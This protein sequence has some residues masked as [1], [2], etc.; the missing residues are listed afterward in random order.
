MRRVLLAAIFVS[1]AA[2]AAADE[3]VWRIGFLTSGGSFMGSVRSATLR[4]LAAN[5]FHEGKNIELVARWANGDPER[6]PA[7]ARELAGAKVDVIIAVSNAAIG[8][9]KAAAPETPIV[10]S[11][12]GRDPLED[13]FVR[14]YARPGGQITG[15]VMLAP[16][17]T[18]KRIQILREALPAARRVGFLA[19]ET[20]APAQIE[21]TR[22]AAAALGLSL[23]V[24]SARGPAEFSSAFAKL[25]ADGADGVVVA[26]HPFFAAEGARLA[27]AAIEHR[28]VTS[29]EWGF[30]AR[31][32]CTFGY[33]ADLAK[34]RYRTGEYV[35]R[36][37]RGADP[38]ELPLE[39]PERFELVVNLRT[40]AAL[41][42]EV[43]SSLLIR[44]D[45]VI[46]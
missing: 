12:A 3:R 16:E 38:A 2:P 25:R 43:P 35:A 17:L 37:L 6:L 40:A 8:A 22:R 7:L 31:D 18:E 41:G 46:E 9:A 23:T 44:A 29:C 4:A 5:G 1:L 33:G 21:D 39:Q 32:G 42:V 26:S 14:S 19:A 10:M 15:I 11:F 36:I 24:A 34:L 45:E 20:T 30:M 13:G 28:F 27:A